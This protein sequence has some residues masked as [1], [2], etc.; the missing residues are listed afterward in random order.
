MKTLHRDAVVITLVMVL[1]IAFAVFPTSRRTSAQTGGSCYVDDIF[2][3]AGE[4]TDPF[5]YDAMIFV[6]AGYQLVLYVM[7]DYPIG[8]PYQGWL[9]AGYQVVGGS[10][11]TVVYDTVRSTWFFEAIFTPAVPPEGGYVYVM[12]GREYAVGGGGLG[13]YLSCKKGEAVGEDVVGRVPAYVDGRLCY[14]D[15]YAVYTYGEKIDIYGI[16]NSRGFPVLNVT[17]AELDAVPGTEGVNTLV[18]ASEDG[19]VQVFRLGTSNTYETHAGLDFVRFK[20]LPASEVFC[21]HIEL[22][23][24]E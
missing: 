23:E 20:G 6:P 19:E 13:I 3:H 21:G 2:W 4:G 8:G 7:N 5:D 1:V 24:T 22:L 14:W 12:G 18:K 11:G 16:E 15:E 10:D 9:S 17:Q